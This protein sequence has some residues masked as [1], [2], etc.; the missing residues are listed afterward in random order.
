MSWHCPLPFNSLS[1]NTLGRYA[2]CCESGPSPHHCTEMTMS[3]F[4]KSDYMK[5]VRKG[6]LSSNPLSVKEI[7]QACSQCKGKEDQGAI[8]KRMRE[9]KDLEQTP[10]MELK[11]IGNICNYACAMCHPV[12]SSKLA[13]EWGVDIP[14]WFELSG[15]WYDDFREISKNYTYFKFSGGEPFMSP[16]TNKILDILRESGNSH[17]IKLQ[18]NSNGSASKKVLSRLLEDFAKINFCFSVDAWGERNAAIR[19]HSTWEFTEERLWDYGE[20]LYRYDNLWL[21]IHPCIMTL[22]IGY[23]YEFQEYVQQHEFLKPRLQFSVSN[24]LFEPK[25]LNAAHLSNDIKE[26]Y[27][28]DNKEFLNS[29][30]VYS[31]DSVFNILNNKTDEN[32]ELVLQGMERISNAE[33]WYPEFFN[34]A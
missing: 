22:N 17:N 29:G 26:K 4:D 19:K 1:S 25:K 7:R 2:L 33:K 15:D 27:L 24:T 30:L 3:E 16:T 8:S 6:F 5:K 13:E 12:S 32:M 31:S 20:L 18:F 10:F 9:I 23:L 34:Y 21:S 28:N 11:L 14:K